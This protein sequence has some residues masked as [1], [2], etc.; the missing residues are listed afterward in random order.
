MGS[1]YWKYYLYIGVDGG[2]LYL[3]GWGWIEAE[4]F[5]GQVVGFVC[6]RRSVMRRIVGG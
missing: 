5:I 6:R 2:W 1:F 3:P 4:G